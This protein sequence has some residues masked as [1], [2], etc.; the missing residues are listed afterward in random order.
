MAADSTG[1]TEM[2]L[3]GGVDIAFCTDVGIISGE[4]VEGRFPAGFRMRSIRIVEVRQYGHYYVGDLY[5]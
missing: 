1:L 2:D 4:A 5:D 3:D